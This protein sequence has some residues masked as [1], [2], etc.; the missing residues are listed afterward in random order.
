MLAAIL[1]TLGSQFQPLRAT[2]LFYQVSSPAT[3]CQL[4]GSSST[5]IFDEYLFALSI[6]PALRNVHILSSSA[7]DLVFLIS[8]TTKLARQIAQ[9]CD[10]ASSLQIYGL[11][12][13]LIH[14]DIIIQPRIS[15]KEVVQIPYIGSLESVVGAF[16]SF[17]ATPSHFRS[18]QPARHTSPA[19]RARFLHTL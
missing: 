2:Y 8:P 6:H 10:P 12:F 14:E 11:L 15:S 17:Q 16:E 13:H 19:R 7:I 3:T 18:G 1:P 5:N 9:L 4:R